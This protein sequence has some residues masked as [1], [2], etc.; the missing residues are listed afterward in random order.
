[1]MH[2]LMWMRNID[3]KTNGGIMQ[4]IMKKLNELVGICE[5]RV[6]KC[7]ADAVKNASRAAVL[8]TKEAELDAINKSLNEKADRLAEL[9]SVADVRAELVATSNEI[10]ELRAKFERERIAFDKKVAADNESIANARADIDRRLEKLSAAEIRLDE[11]K[12]T[13]KAKVI[14]QL[15]KEK[16][17]RA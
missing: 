2:L 10:K 6:A 5:V 11:D 4:N 7:E 15:H 13:Y 16:V 17:A 8:D 3:N 14:D 9:Q 1:M 12:K